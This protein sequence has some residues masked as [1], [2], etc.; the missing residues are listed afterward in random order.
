MVSGIV[1]RSGNDASVTMVRN[2][3]TTTQ[4]GPNTYRREHGC[5]PT[6][7]NCFFI[8]GA[9]RDD[10]DLINACAA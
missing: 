10:D 2:S 7:R 5:T 3:I 8:G 4:I 6:G 9:S 1:T